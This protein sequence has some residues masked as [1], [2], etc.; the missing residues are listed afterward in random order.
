VNLTAVA[1]GIAALLLGAAAWTLRFHYLPI[2]LLGPLAAEQYRL[3]LELAGTVI[4]IIGLALLI[5]GLFPP[6][7]T[8]T[9]SKRTLLRLRK[10]VANL[11]AGGDHYTKRRC[12][13]LI[14]NI[15]QSGARNF[16]AD[17]SF[18]WLLLLYLGSG[19]EQATQL[20]QVTCNRLKRMRRSILFVLDRAGLIRKRGWFRG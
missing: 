5:L 14:A 8:V 12:G 2:P 18:D 10:V 20:E 1:T 3:P 19:T 15:S 6:T 16:G 7:Y 17:G 11:L 4:A 13:E 9:L